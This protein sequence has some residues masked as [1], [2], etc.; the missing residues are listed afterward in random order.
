MRSQDGRK[1]GKRPDAEKKSAKLPKSCA[2][3]RRKP[4]SA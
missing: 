3:K 4:K 2:N 1:H